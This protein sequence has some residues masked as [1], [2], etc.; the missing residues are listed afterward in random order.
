MSNDNYIDC[1]K[2]LSGWA[3]EGYTSFDK[4]MDNWSY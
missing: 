3:N 4:I 2:L 1:M